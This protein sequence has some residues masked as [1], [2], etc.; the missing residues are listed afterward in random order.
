MKILLLTKKFPYPLKDGESQAIHGLSK[1]LS[2]LGCEVS[3]LAM[4]TSKH[5]FSGKELPIKMAHYTQ[6]RTVG[7]NNAISPIDALTNLV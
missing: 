2:E 6:V 1:S 4:N 3:L 7:V 5:F